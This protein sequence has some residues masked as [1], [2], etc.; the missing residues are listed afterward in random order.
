MR[1]YQE[2]FR[3]NTSIKKPKENT[4]QVFFGTV[5]AVPFFVLIEAYVRPNRM[6]C[7]K[8]HKESTAPWSVKKYENITKNHCKRFFALEL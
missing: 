1:R 8:K 3:L 5:F 6:F 4:D 2:G 7:H